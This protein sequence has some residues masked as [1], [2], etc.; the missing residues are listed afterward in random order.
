L[1]L[2]FRFRAVKSGSNPFLLHSL[3]AE[4]MSSEVYIENNSE[5]SLRASL[6]CSLDFPSHP[7][8]T[9]SI[10][11]TNHATTTAAY[12]FPLFTFTCASPRHH[13]F[14]VTA[15]PPNHTSYSRSARQWPRIL[16]TVY[17]ATELFAPDVEG[18]RGVSGEALREMD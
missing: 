5:R 2:W 11:L 12:T 18:Q 3:F 16:A 9:L 14:Q 13:R 8:Y 6:C 1:G 15:F 17:L 7:S 4:A 10:L